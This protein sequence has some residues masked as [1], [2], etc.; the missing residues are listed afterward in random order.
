MTA[1]DFCT[2]VNHT[3][4]PKVS[5]HH[6]SVPSKVSVQTAVRWLHSLGFEKLSSKKGIYINGHERQDVVDYR[7]LYLRK[8]EIL[9]STHAPPPPCTSTQRKIGP[10][11][12]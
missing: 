5:D 10:H 9:A 1:T 2:W 8:H 7:K 3:L 6:P 11:F 4:L 12:S